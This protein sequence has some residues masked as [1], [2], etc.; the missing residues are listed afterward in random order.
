MI[1]TAPNSEFGIRNSE[2]LTTL[3]GRFRISDFGFRIFHP[4]NPIPEDTACGPAAF[5]NSECRIQHS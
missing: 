5:L 2:I 3:Q 4:V 1:T